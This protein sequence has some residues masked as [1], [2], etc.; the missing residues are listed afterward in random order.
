MN[1]NKINMRYSLL[2]LFVSFIIFGSCR[3]KLDIDIPEAEK[4]IVLNG[5]IN[6]DSTIRVRVTKSKSVLDNN[7]I[8]NL[9]S[10]DVK[11]FKNDIF[12]EN[13]VFNDS[14]YFYSNVKPEMNA[15][16]EIRTDYPGLNSVKADVFLLPP[17]EIQSVDTTVLIKIN[18]YGEGYIDT[19]YE[20]HFNLRFD[21][22]AATSDYYFLSVNTLYPVFFYTDT[23][24]IFTG[25]EEYSYYFDTTDPVLNKNNNEFIIDG[26]NG[27]V[28]SDE[29][30]NGNSYTLNFIAD[31]YNYKSDEYVKEINDEQYPVIIVLK[32]LKVTEAVY[33]YIFSFNLNEQTRFDPFAQPVQVYSNVENGL[34]LF[35]GYTITTDTIVLNN[36]K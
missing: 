5:I 9:S 32:L 31:F 17:S 27:R 29:L 1:F 8:E 21:D 14:G 13:L 30:F 12:V 3:K 4:H 15:N 35:S 18:N 25:Y 26:I 7:E 20:I 22:K 24:M 23:S 19:T 34:G 10:A 11:L 6:P 2:I 28:F 36:L 33:N 16:Y